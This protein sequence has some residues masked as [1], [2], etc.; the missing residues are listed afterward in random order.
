MK[1]NKISKKKYKLKKTNKTKYNNISIGAGKRKS[2]KKQTKN[3]NKSRRQFKTDSFF[4][5]D[6]EGVLSISPS[7]KTLQILKNCF[8][9]PLNLYTCTGLKQ[10]VES[11]V[12]NYENSVMGFLKTVKN[13]KTY[14]SLIVPSHNMSMLYLYIRQTNNMSSAIFSPFF[15]LFHLIGKLNASFFTR[16]I[17]YIIYTDSLYK[18]SFNEIEGGGNKDDSANN[19]QSE[20]SNIEDSNYWLSKI[21][22]ILDENL[23]IITYINNNLDIHI[24]GNLSK[25]NQNGGG[26]LSFLKLPSL[27]SVINKVIYTKELNEFIDDMQLM[28]DEFQAG[29]IENNCKKYGKV[30]RACLEKRFCMLVDIIFNPIRHI[31]DLESLYLK[32]ELIFV[33]D[34]KLI[35]KYIKSIIENLH[36]STNETYLKINN[37]LKQLKILYKFIKVYN[38][39]IKNLENNNNNSSPNE[40]NNSEKSQENCS[41]IDKLFMSI[42][43]GFWEDDKN[44]E[45][46]IKAKENF[47]C[48]QE[49]IMNLY[50]NKMI[51]RFKSYGPGIVSDLAKC[52]YSNEYL[53][54]IKDNSTLLGL[55][56]KSISPDENTLEITFSNRKKYRFNDA[57][58]I[59]AS[60]VLY[61]FK[62][63]QKPV[64]PYFFMPKK[65]L[66]FIKINKILSKPPVESL[67]NNEKGEEDDDTDLVGEEYILDPFTFKVIKYGESASLESLESRRFE[68]TYKLY[69]TE[70]EEVVTDEILYIDGPGIVKKIDCWCRRICSIDSEKRIKKRGFFNCESI[71]NNL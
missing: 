68:C 56:V 22:I 13:S 11:V 43:K 58:R 16:Y 50:L 40:S 31:R 47:V 37:Y 70:E 14:I 41:N 32:L 64:F 17:E 1:I 28:E 36:N 15:D 39:A 7:H 27:D 54:E 67:N 24:N 59:D 63:S 3:R 60:K 9:F 6:G 20:I 62:G 46:R 71:A 49:Y 10:A 12:D 4:D 34:G 25:N 55:D 45:K 23:E 61:T 21:N 29:N 26:I 5:P 65:Y 66:L 33:N 30:K 2:N 18:H 38:D 48:L 8:I 44:K 69:D 53:Q 35:E 51:D 42:L 52:D 19:N 57:N